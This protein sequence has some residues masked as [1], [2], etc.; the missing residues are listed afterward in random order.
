MNFHKPWKISS[1]AKKL[2]ANEATESLILG[3]CRLNDKNNYV[4]DFF[5]E[6]LLI[7]NNRS[8]ILCGL[9]KE[10]AISENFKFFKQILSR[11]EWLRIGRI[12]QSAFDVF[13]SIPKTKRDGL[14]LSCK[15]KVTTIHG[16]CFFDHRC[17]PFQLCQNGNLWL[18]LCEISMG[19]KENPD[20]EA[21]I[22]NKKNRDWYL[23]TQNKFVLQGKKLEPTTPDA[24]F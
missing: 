20:Y 13:F 24:L 14:I 1:S 9:P 7:D 15:M 11:E 18:G 6:R 5:Q 2:F 19:D 21:S 17:T 4:L 22:I 12:N 16:E 8:W 3:F 10:V 23:Y